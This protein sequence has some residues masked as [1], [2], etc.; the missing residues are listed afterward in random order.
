MAHPPTCLS[1]KQAI[2]THRNLRPQKEINFPFRHLI[3]HTNPSKSFLKPA[4][5]RFRPKIQ[6][7]VKRRARASG[8]GL[9]DADWRTRTDGRGPAEVGRRTRTGGRGPADWRKWAGGRGRADAD[10]RTGGKL[11]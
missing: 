8:R 7:V 1:Y 11:F 2:S 10:R 6:G 9:A 5:F 3:R 4:W